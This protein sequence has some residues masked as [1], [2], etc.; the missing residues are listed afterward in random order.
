M[1][2]KHNKT[3][4]SNAQVRN[5]CKQYLHFRELTSE[6]YLE[7]F[8]KRSA[9]LKLTDNLHTWLVSMRAGN[10]KMTWECSAKI[11]G[12]LINEESYAI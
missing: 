3:K 6:A 11:Q 10:I 12:I 1:S 4:Y 2:T 5:A 7:G 8:I 9:Y